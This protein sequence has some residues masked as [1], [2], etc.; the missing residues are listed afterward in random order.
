MPRYYIN[1][2]PEANGNHEVHQADCNLLPDEAHRFFLGF[3]NRCSDA[4]K[5]AK[6]HYPQVNGCYYC[7]NECCNS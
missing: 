4:L 1:T 5:E 2:Q 3:F 7:S 6:T